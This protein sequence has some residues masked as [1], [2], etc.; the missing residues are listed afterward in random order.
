MSDS[1]KGNSG[2]LPPR[3]VRL[4]S[5]NVLQIRG[6]VGGLS[7]NRMVLMEKCGFRQKDLIFG[8]KSGMLNRNGTGGVFGENAA[9]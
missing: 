8:G 5:P 3:A 6:V 4:A 2:L 9:V 1:I 7:N